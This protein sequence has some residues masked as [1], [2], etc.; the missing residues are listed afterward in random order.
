VSCSLRSRRTGKPRPVSRSTAGGP[1]APKSS[2]PTLTTENQCSSRWAIPTATSR[3]S[4]S[5]ARARWSRA[6]SAMCRSD[7][8]VE[9]RDPVL[10]APSLQLDEHPCRSARVGEGGGPDLHGGR[11]G[12]HHLHG[13]RSPCHSPD[14]DDGSRRKGGPAV[15]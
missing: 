3:S 10:L 6:D 7:Q 14:A 1:T 12:Q 11:S 15:V 5:R 4:T 9:T 8:L 13:V 2:R